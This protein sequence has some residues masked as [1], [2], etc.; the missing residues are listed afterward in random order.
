MNR[1]DGWAASE[2]CDRLKRWL[3]SSLRLRSQALWLLSLC[4]C[5]LPDGHIRD[6]GS[7]G[8]ATQ[9][10]DAASKMSADA[11]ATTDDDGGNAKSGPMDAGMSS[12]TGASLV[13][14]AGGGDC[15]WSTQVDSCHSAGAPSEKDR[16]SAALDGTS[17]MPDLYLAWTKL[18]VGET[19]LMGQASDKAWQT[20]G[21]DLDGRCTNSSTCPG[22]HNVQSCRASTDQIP[23]DGELCRD[24][25]FAS[26]QPIA[27]AVPEI[28]KRFGISESLFNCNLWRG[29]YNMMLKVSGYNGKPDD[30]QVRVD[31][32]ISPGVARQ[33]PWNCPLDNFSDM[34]PV[35]RPV[36]AWLIDPDNLT[37][38]IDKP[39]Q[40]PDS[41]VADP[42]A[43]VRG[44][45]MVAMMPDDALVRLAGDGSKFRG[46]A[47][48]LDRS[49]WTGQLYIAQ[50]GT[51]R[52]RDG[53]LAGRV[54]S[55][56]LLQSF[57]QIGLCPGVGLDSFYNDL[58]DYVHQNADLLLDGSVD[59]DRD[60]DAMSFAV[61]FESQQAVPGNVSPATPLV[62]CCA[63]GT[64]LEDCDPKCG[65][66][67]LNG[68]EKCDTA[69]ASG[70]PGACPK[71]CSPSDA[72]TPT[73][74]TGDACDT[75]CAPH[76]ITAIGAQDG[77]CPK[78]ANAT[79]DP[80][81]TALCGNGVIEK[82]ETCDPS[83]A[84]PSCSSSDKCLMVSSTGAAASCDLSCAYTMVSACRSGDG[85]CPASCS[86]SND[87]DCSSSCGDGR[88]DPKETCE[89]GGTGPACP[90]SCDDQDACTTDYKTGKSENCNVTC[91]HVRISKALSGDGCCPPGANSN[92]DSDC[93]AV[94]GN[95][96]VEG[97]EEC[98]DGNKQSGDGCTPD[99]KLESKLDQCLAEVGPNDHP[100]CARCN[101]EKCQSQTLSCYG[102]S[103]ATSI[104]LCA[105]LVKCGVD[106]G[107]ASDACYCGTASFTTC[108][109]G[110]GNGP[111]RAEVEAASRS[112]TVGDI[113]VRA[114][115]ASY[116]VGRA[117]QLAA[118][119]R[120][121]CASECGITQ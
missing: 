7:N 86:S 43:Y 50:D 16:P 98:D 18:W 100:D 62:E 83:S 106:K 27:A 68:T 84:C 112:T 81:C 26:L 15:W 63:P 14:C 109:L 41:K 9:V 76:P 110:A 39:G 32:Y 93:M 35:W 117:N 88:L 97:N 69:I 37:G 6:A 99:C 34:Y 80:D 121:N 44:G 21:L 17:S 78:G 57:R 55:Q 116:P 87:D 114:D 92:T 22:Q 36:T 104:K 94:C 53:I 74:L 79:S 5:L 30:S 119:T 13:S 33:Q 49:L 115:D 89:S 52:M 105:D 25:T 85:C 59:P 4:G 107:C 1:L 45:Y 42:H 113:I 118:C 11:T 95:M 64:A 70:K 73:A 46:F 103:D 72:C 29:S 66:G 61:A 111:C 38:P 90:S 40:L 56:D 75:D 60:C 54:R 3:R 24:N 82:A 48:R 19:N 101:C 58:T 51:W 120:D 108:S 20:F 8:S 28:G 2:C 47:L 102:G 96:T 65:D 77:C 12:P 91:S 10:S 23:F 71:S 31:L 67:R